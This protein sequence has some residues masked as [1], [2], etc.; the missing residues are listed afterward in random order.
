[1]ELKSYVGFGS[2][3]SDNV[4][5][6]I[7]AETFETPTIPGIPRPAVDRSLATLEFGL[8]ARQLFSIDFEAFTFLNHG[9]FGA[10]AN[11]PAEKASLFRARAE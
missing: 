9:A 11:E 8:S 4:E 6:M 5:D 3:H 7:A 10:V 1:M 2:F